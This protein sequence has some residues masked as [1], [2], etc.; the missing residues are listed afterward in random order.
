MRNFLKIVCRYRKVR[1]LGEIFD[2]YDMRADEEEQII[3]VVLFY[4]AL[5]S[6][7]QKK[8]HGSFLCRKYGAKRAY[9][10]MKKDDSLIGGFI[11]RVGNDE[12]D[13]STKGRLDRLEQR[14]TRR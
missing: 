10:E 8:R 1:L 7:E 2:A 5:P 3:R 14:L 12:Y 9:I 11:L 4:T 6:E 13:R